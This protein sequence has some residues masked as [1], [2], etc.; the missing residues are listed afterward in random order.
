MR[1]LGVGGEGDRLRLQGGIDDDLDEVRRLFRP[2]AV[3]NCWTSSP[4]LNAQTTPATPNTLQQ[5]GPA[6]GRPLLR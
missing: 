1:Q 2:G 4:Q 5:I 6:L 3:E